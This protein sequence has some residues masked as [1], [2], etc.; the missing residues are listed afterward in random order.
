MEVEEGLETA[1]HFFGPTNLPASRALQKSTL[2]R[3]FAA[4]MKQTSMK[5]RGWGRQH[6]T[7]VSILASVPSCR[8]FDSK[9]SQNCSEESSYEYC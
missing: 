1:T 6:S 2:L 5:G 7:M 3:M 4:K 8:G 9:G